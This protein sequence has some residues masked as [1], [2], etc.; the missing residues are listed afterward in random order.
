MLEDGRTWSILETE[1]AGCPEIS[2]SDSTVDYSDV[3]SKYELAFK[4]T[5][6]DTAS[7]GGKLYG[8]Y[9]SAGRTLWLREVP[10][11]GRVYLFETLAIDMSLKMGDTLVH[12]NNDFTCLASYSDYSILPTIVSIEDSI[13]LAGHFR[14]RL[15]FVKV[16]YPLFYPF[17]LSSP[18][19]EWPCSDYTR[20]KPIDT[21]YWIEGIGS[22]IGF[23]NQLC[24]GNQTYQLICLQDSNGVS[25][26]SDLD[27]TYSCDSVFIDF[28]NFPSGGLASSS[29][30]LDSKQCLDVLNKINQGTVREEDYVVDHFDLLG[31]PLN[32]TSSSPTFKQ[33]D[34]TNEHLII[35][36]ISNK[37]EHVCSFISNK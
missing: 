29:T 26:Y 14:K 1:Y 9:E 16:N 21:V 24:G 20:Y 8:I 12:E 2:S 18:Y 22:T 37:A 30:S 13:F 5:K 10:D 36:R 28:P 17:P 34:F 11:S 7:E 23:F 32:M 31:R 27:S 6:V 33:G 15:G 4:F 25:L 19:L 3:K 35:I